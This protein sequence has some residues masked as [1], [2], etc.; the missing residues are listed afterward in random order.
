[1]DTTL[2]IGLLVGLALGAL[3][4]W[5]ATRPA[6]AAR[7][8]ELAGAVAERELLR[9]R[10]LDLEAL[11]SED[12]Q[13]SAALGPMR[14]AL[15]RMERTVG[16]LERDRQVQYGAL[17]ARLEEVTATT[18]AL[19]D[20]TATLVGSLQSSSVRGA[21]GEAQLRRLLEHAGLLARCD[22]DEQVAAVTEHDAAVR[23]DAVVRLPGGKVLVVDAK[24]PLTRFLAAQGDSL[25]ET[26]RATHLRGHAAALRGH[27]DTLAAKAYW[28]AFP[29][30]PEMVVCF[31]PSDAVL[32]A[33]LAHDPTLYDDA[34]ARRVVLSSPAT[35]LA[36]LRTVAFTWQQ[37]ALATNAAHLL[38]LGKELYARI[39]TLAGHTTR[40]GAQLSRSVE[41]YNA[42]VGTLESRV[43][44]TARRMH[45]LELVSAAPPTVDVV[46]TAARPLTSAELLDALDEEV[47]RPELD[48]TTPRREAVG[49]RDHSA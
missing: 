27:V 17:G 7:Q 3:L 6:S 21:W 1:M 36:L 24:V 13:T 30:T 28:T 48:L 14:E 33:A 42:M 45:E 2:I 46:E 47:R 15:A 4:A 25:D 8:A 16:T 41:A 23:P 22:F 40:L 11:V 49:R 20:Q 39:G 10:C 43:L 19:R 34:L 26:Q 38:T 37:D 12:T 18:S 5:L 29:T 35:L 9:E 32:A 31:V 44:V